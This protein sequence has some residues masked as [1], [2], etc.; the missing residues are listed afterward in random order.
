MV[1]SDRPNLADPPQLGRFQKLGDEIE[2]ED[3]QQGM[4]VIKHKSGWWWSS[5]W[6]LFFI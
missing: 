3:T 1:D 6:G 4:D 2:D 5:G